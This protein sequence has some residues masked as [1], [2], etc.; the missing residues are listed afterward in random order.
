MH[1]EKQIKQKGFTLIELLVT[2]S[3]F[4]IITSIVLV[5]NNQFNNSVIIN[6]LA[7]EVALSIRQA[8][9][10]GL[11]VKEVPGSG[12]FESGYGVYFDTNSPD[13]FLLFADTKTTGLGNK[14]LY[15]SGSTNDLII[16]TFS[17]THG[18]TISSL[19]G[20]KIVNGK[21][22]CTED[23]SIVFN[24]P[25]PEANM[26]AKKGL[27]EFSEMRVTLV[28]P[29]GAERIVQIESTGQISIQTP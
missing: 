5:N 12:D 18:N 26:K 16:E 27:T 2:V 15:D 23:I 19:C 9:S 1:T 24:R 21:E 10:F 29:S 4:S 8:Q 6:N 25:D 17:I 11:N 7:Y 13:T 22:D 28:S 14:N 3:I 20:T